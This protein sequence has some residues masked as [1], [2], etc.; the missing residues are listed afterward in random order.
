M[1][2][3][4]RRFEDWGIIDCNECTHYWDS[5]CDGVSK[6]S[7]VGCNSYLAT[8]SVVIPERIN[9][10]ENRNRWLTLWCL[11]LSIFWILEM[12]VYHG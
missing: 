6:G 4:S 3:T 7:R 1:E 12:V 8:R 10:L 11:M 5:S 9:A 2:K